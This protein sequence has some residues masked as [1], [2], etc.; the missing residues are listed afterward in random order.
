MNLSDRVFDLLQSSIERGE[1]KPGSM[2]SERSLME[3]TG[4]GRTP[5]R[6]AIQRLALNQMLRIHPGRGI[7]IPS[8][9][10][11][12]QLSSLEVRRSTELLAVTLACERATAEDQAEMK[13]LLAYLDRNLSLD[14]YAD[15][16]R[17][18]H[19]LIIKAAHN[20]YLAT[21]MTPLQALSRRFWLMHIR[22][23][24]KEISQG[25]ALHQKVLTAI[26][27]RDLDSASQAS[28]GLND[29]L[30]QFALDVVSQKA[31]RF[32]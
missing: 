8:V 5:V 26:T 19:A 13:A 16:V 2:V 11:E 17:Q 9:S 30:V 21:L 3:L 29:Y 22:D 15:T 4:S 18:T 28:L 25:K 7:E 24:D 12:D 20:P 23:A 27:E 31:R 1:L 32:G 6:E 10:V 14:D